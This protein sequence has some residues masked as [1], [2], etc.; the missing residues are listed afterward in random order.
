MMGDLPDGQPGDVGTFF[1][2]RHAFLVTKPSTFGSAD[3][4]YRKKERGGSLAGF[5][6]DMLLVPQR[7]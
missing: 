3:L 7:E 5:S 6:W 4:P 2:G 1:K